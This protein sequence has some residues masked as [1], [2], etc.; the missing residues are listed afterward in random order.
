MKFQKLVFVLF[1][2]L[3]SAPAGAAASSG[4]IALVGGS[5]VDLSGGAP[6]H[7]AVVLVEG[8]KIVAIGRADEVSV[9]LG[10]KS[11][12]SQAPG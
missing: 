7:D 10:Q 1:C 11:S 8:E 9:H 6:L 5:I 4:T 2:G 3:L 12:M